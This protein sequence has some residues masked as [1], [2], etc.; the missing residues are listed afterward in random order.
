MSEILDIFRQVC[1]LK[2]EKNKIIK[3]KGDIIMIGSIKNNISHSLLNTE[4]NKTLSEERGVERDTLSGKNPSDNIGVMIAKLSLEA[5]KNVSSNSGKRQILTEGLMKI[6]DNENTNSEQKELARLGIN[7]V[8]GNDFSDITAVET[9]YKFLDAIMSA[10]GGPVGSVIARVTSDSAKGASTN[11]QSRQILYGGMVAIKDNENT[12]SEQKELARLGINIVKGNDFSDITAVETRYKFLDAIEN[13]SDKP[14]IP[15]IAE[16]TF[17]SAVEASDLFEKRT[18]LRTGLEAICDN[19]GSTAQQK[20]I[21]RFGIDSGAGHHISD[22]S[23]VNAR[24][25]VMKSLF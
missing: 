24:L 18:M 10:C 17:N 8:K 9:R 20:D 12:N 5:S 22:S 14:L 19:P 15:V 11:F 2:I 6:K 21:A 4:R 25:T 23:A 16:V 3:M 1:L 13:K 7:I